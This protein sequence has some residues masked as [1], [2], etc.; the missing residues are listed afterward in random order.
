MAKKKRKN[1]SQLNKK[2]QRLFN[3]KEIEKKLKELKFSTEQ[4]EQILN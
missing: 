3:N 1:V 4:I 2:Q